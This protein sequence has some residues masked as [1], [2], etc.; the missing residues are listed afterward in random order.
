[1]DFVEEEHASA[2]EDF[3]EDEE[4]CDAAT[5]PPEVD[6]ELVRLAQGELLPPV[7]RG[8]LLGH[9]ALA[10]DGEASLD[11]SVH[12]ASSGVS[13]AQQPDR[14]SDMESGNVSAEPAAPSAVVAAPHAATADSLGAAGAVNNVVE[15]LI[16]ATDIATPEPT[17]SE[18]AAAGEEQQPAGSIIAPATPA[19]P[20]T[21]SSSSS[22]AAPPL[23]LHLARRRVPSSASRSQ[24]RPR[25]G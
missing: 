22:S 1:M 12:G 21:S 25:A 14:P 23:R 11:M 3:E 10:D 2:S 16:N 17:Q 5:L 8:D 6:A 7:D 9:G 13:E 18:A 4:C 15:E 20:G 19:A 24:G